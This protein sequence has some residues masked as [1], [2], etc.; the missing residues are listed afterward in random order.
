[1]Q[2]LSEWN[3]V[4]DLIIPDGVT[5]IR[6]DAFSNCNSLTSV[7]ILNSVKSIWDDAFSSCH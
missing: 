4:T 5:S 6:D 2:P 7:M 1:M 3:F